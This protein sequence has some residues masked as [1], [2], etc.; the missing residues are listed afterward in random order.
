LAIKFFDLPFRQAAIK[1]EPYVLEPG[2]AGF[3]LFTGDTYIK[4][5][6]S[7][8]KNMNCSFHFSL[9]NKAII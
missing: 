8:K 7:W 5:Y 9:D 4:F 3:L 2:T 1:N 6:P